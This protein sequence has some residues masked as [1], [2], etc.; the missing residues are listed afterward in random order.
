MAGL[1]GRRSGIFGRGK[2]PPVDRRR[3]LALKP[4]RNP[5]IEWG[6]REEPAGPVSIEIPLQRR[7]VPRPLMWL[8]AKLARQE[9]P[10]TKKLNLDPVGS[11]VWRSA[12]GART[13][14]ELIW[15]LAAEYKLNRRDAEFSMLEFLRQ[16]SVRNLIGFAHIPE[17]PPPEKA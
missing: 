5:E 15:L 16:L 2:G 1:L 7:P 17:N 10:S 3:G 8:A 9:P 4:L 6:P 11:F 14:R 13:V 12:D